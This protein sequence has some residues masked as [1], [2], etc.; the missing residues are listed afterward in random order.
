MSDALQLGN[1][2]EVQYYEE[3][4]YAESYAQSDG[5]MTKA[6]D[7]E[8]AQVDSLPEGW[9]ELYDDTVGSHYYYNEASG[10]ASWVRPEAAAEAEVGWGEESHAGQE[11]HEG[12]EGHKG[13]AGYDGQVGYEEQEEQE[14]REDPGYGAE[15][16]FTYDEIS[17]TWNPLESEGGTALATLRPRV[18]PVRPSRPVDFKPPPP[19]ACISGIQS[20]VRAPLPGPTHGA[21]TL[22][23]WFPRSGGEPVAA[24]PRPRPPAP[25]ERP[26]AARGRGPAAAADGGAP[27]HRRQ[28]VPPPGARGAPAQAHRQEARRGDPPNLNPGPNT[29]PPVQAYRQEARRGDPLTSTLALTPAPCPAPPPRIESRFEGERTEFR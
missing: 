2:E 11:G 13:Y 18:T 6:L 20:S 27:P 1:F 29:S 7:Q 23:P 16:S 8:Y 10:E 17:R 19:P 14:Q 25:P 5:T 22:P 4:S 26:R 3:E 21:T 28:A 24:G 9:V 15:A 12:Y